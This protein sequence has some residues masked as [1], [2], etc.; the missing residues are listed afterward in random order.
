[1]DD[2]LWLSELDVKALLDVGALIDALADGFAALSS[3][4]VSSPARPQLTVPDGF[5]L[6]MPAHRQGGSI[7]VKMVSVFGGNGQKGMASHLALICLFDPHTGATRA[8][9]DGTYITA[10]RTAAAAAL[11]VRLV[12]RTGSRVLAVIGA[13]VQGRAHVQALPH[14]R[15]FDEIRV[16][17]RHRDDAAYAARLHPRAQ[18]AESF[19]AAVRGADVVALCTSS[20]D[21][22]VPL[23]WL[24]P[25]AHVTSVG[26]ATSGSELAPQVLDH[27]RIFVETRR[28][29]AEPPEGCIELHGR[30][31]ATG[32]E[33]GEVILGTR[34]GR[35][36]QS[37]LTVYKSM[38]TA[39]ED[40]TAA[41]LVYGAAISSGHGQRLRQYS[42]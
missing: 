33:L 32:T 34:A 24:K 27:A 9:M 17:A 18:A 14:V 31:S 30:D 23:D 38:G 12:A 6:T 21:P 7:G 20:P 4:E 11:S 37:E 10:V 13:G 35:S 29:F 5:V 19:E 36:D 3:G 26:H 25:G 22:L 8:V 28:A 2:V 15:E 39:I 41:E 40:L 42:D 16:A 1:M